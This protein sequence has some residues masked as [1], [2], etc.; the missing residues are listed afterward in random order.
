MKLLVT[1][2][3][4]LLG[5]EVVTAARA[6]GHR[7]IGLGRAQ[8]DV[9]DTVAVDQTLAREVPDVLVH[10]AAYTT[11]DLAEDEPDV[12]LRINRDATWHAAAAAQR[13]GA[14]FVYISTDYVFDGTK[15]SPY[16]PGDTPAPLSAYGRS[17]LA[18][19]VASAEVVA[20]AL[21]VR[22]SWLYGEARRNFVTAMIERAAH[23][24]AL[25]VVDDQLGGPSWSRN[26]AETLLDLDERGARGVWHVADRGVCSWAELAT[27]ATRLRGLQAEVTGVPSEEW[28]ARAVRPLY[29]VLDVSA[30]EQLLER[31]MPEWRDAL[32]QFISRQ[33]TEGMATPCTVGR[34]G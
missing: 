7:V 4:G 8:L 32:A 31:E 27:E 3:S 20:D 1:G 5:S 30:T 19:E 28:G 10:C 18:G 9:T 11:V 13:V 22:T 29:S 12:A 17:K 23:G 15:R 14:R 6:R 2:A 34:R 25:T 16:L 24:D 26:V 21:I 33:S